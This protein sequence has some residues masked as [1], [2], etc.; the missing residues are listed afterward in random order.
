MPLYTLTMKNQKE[1]LKKQSHSYC[2]KKNNILRNKFTWRNKRPV[3]KKLWD[4][5]KKLKMTWTDDEI[6]H[7]LGL[8]ESTLWKWLYYPKQDTDPELPQET[9]PDL[10]L[11]VQESLVEAWVGDSLLQGWGHWAQ[12]CRHWTF[13][14]RSP[15]FPLSPLY[16]DRGQIIEGEH[17]L[18][19]QQKIGLKIYWAQPC[20][21][22]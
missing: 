5:W 6:Y 3:C 11:S 22:E 14:R 2:H 17:S 9:D 21:S 19:H 18:S 4:W 1:K 15:L 16:F 20:L 13:W 8:K 7:I 12:Q 10:L